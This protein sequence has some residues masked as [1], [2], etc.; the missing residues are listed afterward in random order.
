M[1]ACM[2]SSIPAQERSGGKQKSALGK[3]QALLIGW[4][5]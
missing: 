5:L 4:R 2:A 1:A 3:W